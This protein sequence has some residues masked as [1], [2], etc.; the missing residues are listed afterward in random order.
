MKI[1]HY[2]NN[3]GSGGAE[4]LLT[5]IL[6]LMQKEGN[7][8]SVLI[9]NSYRNVD[10]YEQHLENGNI[11]IINFQTSF[12]NPLQ[13]FTLIKLL[14]KENYDIVNAHLFPSQYWLSL[15]SFFISDKTKLVKTE[16]SV[17]NERRDY[18]MLRP[19][20]RLIYSRYSKIIAITEQVENNLV[21]W[22]KSSK[23]IKVIYNG[24]NLSQ[25]RDKQHITSNLNLSTQVNLLM[26]ARFDGNHKD[27]VSL[28]NA[29]TYLPQTYHLYLAGEGSFLK[30]VKKHA[31][32]LNLENRVT[33][34]GLR[35][36]VYNLMSRVDL[37]I[38]SSN[39]EGLSG[40]ALESLASGKPF[41]G[42]DV[43]GIN[44]VVPNTCFLFPP[45][46]PIALSNKIKKIIN[47][48]NLQKKMIGE[49]LNHVL[50]YN[51][52]FMVNSYLKLYEVITKTDK[53]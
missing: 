15:A 28:I 31:E 24:I 42:S 17:H 32:K 1:L 5:D 12:Y 29:L 2:I 33:F 9:C 47:D 4:K 37:N 18:K 38:L 7:E 35:T 11:K 3:L 30:S 10:L 13:I 40:V 26:V 41:I 43:V 53:Y 6:P 50:Q 34:L 23:K 51:T 19:L 25:I 49:S 20:E 44:N 39:Q 36:D 21:E 8:V 22:L 48:E 52:P 27:Q 14:R 45:K 16:H 46:S